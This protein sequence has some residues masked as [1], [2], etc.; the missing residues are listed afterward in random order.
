MTKWLTLVVTIV[1][2]AL[3]GVW[4]VRP[5][6]P[7]PASAAADRFSAERA[8]A[9]VRII[10]RAPH[11]TGSAENAAVHAHLVRRLEALGFSVR[12]VDAP[13]PPKSRD[14]L[15]EWGSPVADTA[16]ARTI[17]AL[18]PGQDPVSPLVAVM[19][20]YDSVW[21]S[22]GAADDAAGVAAALEVARAIPQASQ[23]RDLALILTDAE[24]LGLVGARAFFADGIAG[25]PLATRVGV[26]VNMETRGGGGRAAMFETGP[27]N[28]ALMQL[29]AANVADPAANS[30]AVKIYELLPNSTDF[31]PAK[32]RGI[33]GVNFAFIGDAGLYHSPLATPE[34]LDRGALQHLGAQG[35]DI[36]RAL[37]TAPA[38][39]ERAPD[40]VFSDVLGTI[41]IAYPAWVGWLV[42]VAAAA[43]AGVAVR[44]R[45][46]RWREIVAGVADGV[47][48][49]LATAVLAYGVNMLSGADRKSNYY[50]R[51][52]ALPRLE[53]Q[54]L[55]LM[56]AAL[57][58]TLAM[59]G[60]WRSL[61][62]NWLGLFGL[63]FTLA[64]AVQA[65]LP[66]GAPVL[67]WPLLVAALGMA[68]HARLGAVA[69]AL[70]AVFGIA[71]AG[72]LAHFVMLG[73][74]PGMPAAVAV[75]APLLLMLLWPLLPPVPRRT[76][77]LAAL[78]CIVLA[79]GLA[80]WVRLDPL[81]PSVAV[82]SLK[83]GY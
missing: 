30:L 5:P 82:Y 47:A 46:W 9:D 80:L 16:M 44:G 35:L 8:M 4:S 45:G 59:A 55:L 43:L 6:A 74:G 23:R 61:H 81:A 54:V 22:P 28:G 63:N 53:W 20:H 24:E 31:T 12:T 51:L 79:A 39:P 56:A 66:A 40:T 37:L 25:D 71:F 64:I 41:I 29:F 7:L 36:T 48:F 65:V 2:A 76:A 83:N 77:L 18:R 75:F 58:L 21:G 13:L 49:A 69:P 10:A 26:L 38:L 72:N 14:R 17:V 78:V 11:P 42:L 68:L 70:A 62:G 27:G 52:A 57:A 15:R 50:D 73:I 3:L 19:A 60:R 67:A 34:A 33:P 1:A 32:L